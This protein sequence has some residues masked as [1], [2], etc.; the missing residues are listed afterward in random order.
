LYL[1]DGVWHGK[2]LLPEGL[3]RGGDVAPGFQRRPGRRQ[4]LEPGLRLPVLALP[5]RGAYRGD[6]AFGQFCVVLPEQDAVLAVTAGTGDMQAVLNAAWD[7]LLPAMRPGP[8]SEDPATHE[9]LRRTLA[10]LTVR[11]P[12]GAPSSPM[13]ATMSGTAYR[14]EDNELGIEAAALEFGADGST[15]LRVRDDA[16]G[17]EHEIA[18]GGG[19]AWTK[20]ATIF[21]AA[22]SLGGDVRH[23]G[24]DAGR[25]ERR[26][27]RRRHLCREALLLPD[28]RSVPRSPAGSPKAIG[29]C[30]ITAKTCPSARPSIRSW[31]GRQKK[32]SSG[33]DKRRLW[34]PS[35]RRPNRRSRPPNR[36][37]CAPARKQSPRRRAGR[38][39]SRG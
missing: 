5:P 37:G 10:G 36:G 34:I 25:R 23:G 11:L 35:K 38:P 30:S 8:L 1:Q 28:S 29:C 7:H 31:W 18:C 3:G 17:G 22:P 24:A 32:G 12:A 2:R 16:R 39:G 9:A 33:T 26:L 19:G 4:R 21:G 27:G 20:G 13:A 6:G 14:F 15:V